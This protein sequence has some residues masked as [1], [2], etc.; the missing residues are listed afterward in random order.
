ML[1]YLITYYLYIYTFLMSVKQLSQ[2]LYAIDALRGFVI[3][4]MMLDHVRETFFLHH[5][6]PDPMVISETEPMLFLSRTLAH[7]C[8]PVFV[9]LTGLSAYL[10]QQK[11]NNLKMTQSFLL[12]RGIFLIA[13]EL[14]LVNFAWTGQFPP[15][16]IYLQVIWAIGISMVCL[17][18]LIA[19]PRLWQ[20]FIALIIIFGHNLLD[21]V[22]FQNQILQSFWNIL[23]QRGW[24]NFENGLRIRTTY[25]VL[26]WIGLILIGYCFGRTWFQKHITQ[27]HRRKNILTTAIV[28]ILLFIVLRL[29]N[30]YGDHSWQYMPTA[31]ET[32]MSFFNLTKYPPSL[33]FILWNGGIGLLILLFLEKFEHKNWLKPLI[34][35]GSVPMF[36]YILHLFV[37]KLLYLICVSIFGLNHEKYFGFSHISSV[38]I[39]SILLSIA[40]YPAVKA[41]SHF[42]HQN[43]HITFLKYF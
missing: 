19:L 11:N 31:L 23:H 3:L 20:W 26:P 16:T 12:K 10:Y 2:R 37:L 41:F 9:L 32:F 34:T 36:F 13:L 1:C 21:P 6:V 8:A 40:L 33:F 24:I 43:K 4:I 22:T 42:K 28:S 25:P 15:Q 27:A 17:A 7:I 38:W 29:I 14:T 39:T 5:Q 30:I 35:F 18:G